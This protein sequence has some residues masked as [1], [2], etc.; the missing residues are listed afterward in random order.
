MTMDKE[1]FWSLIA[2]C[3]READGDAEEQAQ[4]LEGR[5]SKL[6]PS[7]I[8][9]FDKIYDE[10]RIAAYDWKLWGAAFVINGGCSDDGFEY[11]RGW[12]IAQGEKVYS[13]ALLDPDSLAEVIGVGDG[14]QD[15]ECEDMLYVASR[16]FEATTGKKI[17]KR[18]VAFPREPKGEKW[19]EEDLPELLPRLWSRTGS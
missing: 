14:D 11:F 18:V 12:L 3:R 8:I 4:L 17:P 10:F 7:D 9:E 15:C 2:A 1:K 19:D 16:A 13:Q 6:S 5:L